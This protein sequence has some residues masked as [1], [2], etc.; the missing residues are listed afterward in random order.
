MQYLKVGNRRIYTPLYDIILDIQKINI[1]GKLKIVKSRG[2]NIRVT[3]PVHKDGLENKPSADVYVGDT[4]DNV[5]Y[6][7]FRCFTCDSQGPFTKFVAECLDISESDAKNWLI[8]NYA[9]NSSVEESLILP[10]ILTHSK[11]KETSYISEEI[12]NSFESFHPYMIERK[13]S[14]RII[15]LFEVKYN[16]KSKSLVFPVRDEF[17]NLTMLTERS[18]D[19]KYF[20]IEEDKEK[21]LYLLYYLIKNKIDTCIITE[22]QIDALTACS[23][24]FPCIATIGA[25]SDHQIDLI[26]KSGIRVLYVMFDND[27]AGR[28][29]AFK[30]KKALRKDILVIDVPI[31]IPGKKDINDLSHDEFYMCIENAKKNIW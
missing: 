18:V 11:S 26:N 4:T 31:I 30:L 29:F 16:S 14:K 19:T 28:R 12:L 3:C 13:L 9:D 6:G 8:D 10:E 17:G 7:W 2:S 21:P 1:S 24:G 25:I 20:Y 22:G 15:E 27:A 23:Y 5:E